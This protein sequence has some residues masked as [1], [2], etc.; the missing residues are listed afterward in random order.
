[1]AARDGLIVSL[2]L[3]QVELRQGAIKH[4]RGNGYGAPDLCV[5]QVPPPHISSFDFYSMLRFEQACLFC[6][7]LFKI[8]KKYDSRGIHNGS[9]G[10]CAIRRR[11][12]LS[13]FLTMAIG[14]VGFRGDQDFFAK[15]LRSCHRVYVYYIRWKYRYKTKFLNGCCPKMCNWDV[16]L[17]IRYVY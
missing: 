7:L 12:I 13:G 6:R 11:T 8:T 17:E 2:R 15:Q 14:N 16:C 10:L 3:D 1:V 5:M 9:W 4:G